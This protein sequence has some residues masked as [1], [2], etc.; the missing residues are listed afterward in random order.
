MTTFIKGYGQR[1]SAIRTASGL[2]KEAFARVV[3]SSGAS[4]KNISRIENEEVLPRNATLQKLA[5][6]GG[7][8]TTWLTEGRCVLKPSD[9]VQAEGVG[10]R[11]AAARKAAGVSALTL[12]KAAGLGNTSQNVLRLENGAHRPKLGTVAKIARA[13]HVPVT[14]LAFGA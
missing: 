4:A 1:I 7:V 13:L 2:G 9:I 12:A 3:L 10:E 5:S 8:D 11:I 14:Q 6:F